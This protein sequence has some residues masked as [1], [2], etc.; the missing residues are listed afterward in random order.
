METQILMPDC[1]V[2]KVFTMLDDGYVKLDI[3]RHG[4][5][6]VDVLTN[7]YYE[8]VTMS[9][10]RLLNV[11]YQ[12]LASLHKQVRF[13][14][15]VSCAPQKEFSGGSSFKSV[16]SRHHLIIHG[17][18]HGPWRGVSAIYWRI[19]RVE[20]NDRGVRGGVVQ[21]YLYS[22]ASSTDHMCSQHHRSPAKTAYS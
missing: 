21:M 17:V 11:L 13:D 2:P 5:N 14:A 16:F 15:I 6:L 8:L 4:S 19:V 12:N 1:L 20:G 22:F 3:L 18:L 9:S 10:S 7:D